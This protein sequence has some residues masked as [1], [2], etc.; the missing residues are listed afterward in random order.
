MEWEVRPAESSGR[1][2]IPKKTSV[3]EDIPPVA[4]AAAAAAAAAWL[5]A[6][7]ATAGAD[8]HQG[9]AEAV[10]LEARLESGDVAEAVAGVLLEA[11]DEIG[12]LARL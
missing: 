10:V 8:P 11:C 6:V 1:D 3:S 2:E 7:E 5:G 4:A 12:I 9:L